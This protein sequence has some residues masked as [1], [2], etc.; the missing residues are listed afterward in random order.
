MF[1]YFRLFFTLFLLSSR[2]FLLAQCDPA[3]PSNAVVVTSSTTISGGFDPVW[4]C[5]SAMFFTS[6][7]SV[8][9][10]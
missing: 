10:L 2:F 6:G 3:I 7:G 9:F 8:I 5:S 4:V 1:A